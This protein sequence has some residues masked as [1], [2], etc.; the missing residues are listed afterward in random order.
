MSRNW[1]R[2]CGP[3]AAE[4]DEA[5]VKIAVVLF[6]LGGP[7]VPEAI[8]PFLRNLF[9]DRAVI[10][11]PSFIRLP[12]AR[13]IAR[14]RAPVAR[15]I[16]GRIGGRSPILA[17]TERQARAL[18][19]SLQASGHLARAFVAMRCWQP[20]SDEVAR[21]VLDWAPEI[22]V[23][24]PLYPQFSTTTT[25]S[26]IQDWRRAA[27]EAGIRIPTH[28]VCC[29]PAD[30]GFVGAMAGLIKETIAGL[31]SPL[32]Y[33]LLLSAHGLP[34][35]TIAKGDPYQW[36]VERSAHAIVERLAIPGLD[37]RVCYQSRVGPLRWI[38]PATDAEIRLAGQHA[39]SVVIAP[40]AFVSEHSE[41]L[42]ELDLEYSELAHRCG[43]PEYRRVPTVSA[44]PA[45]I[46]GMA[47]LV[48]RAIE[49]DSAV[50]SGVGRICPPG[51]RR[52][53]Y[54]EGAA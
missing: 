43:V 19:R 51:A 47:S 31:K 13:L 14:R 21:A 12:L 7:D 23:L 2:A 9:A 3:R 4:D 29:F 52:C 27:G 45:F 38:G 41:T 25:G 8:E 26:S 36:Q 42:V 5:A 40:I 35:R 37:W 10:D 28:R 17:E 30:Q 24:L 53:G 49:S 39:T 22:I 34:Q 1:C 20:F 33:R 6:N 44:H 16:Y 11:L 48:R 18:E 54:L 15:K 32:G 46:E 50:T